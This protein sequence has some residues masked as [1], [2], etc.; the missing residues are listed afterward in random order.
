MCG[1]RKNRE[2]PI[3]TKVH[4][5]KLK[6]KENLG[7]GAPEMQDSAMGQMISLLLGMFP[8]VWGVT[9]T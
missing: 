4:A 8:K 1:S 5:V 9:V 3:Q 7:E 6:R 2:T